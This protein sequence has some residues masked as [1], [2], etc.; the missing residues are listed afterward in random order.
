MRISDWS[1][2]VCSSDLA[3]ILDAELIGLQ[4]LAAREAERRDLRDAHRII[5]EQP[6]QPA[7]QP[8]IVADR[9]TEHRA[10]HAEDRIAR[11]CRLALLAVLR[12]DMAD[13]VP[14]HAGQL[15]LVVHQRHQLA[16]D[17]DIAPR[18]REGV[19]HRSE[20]HT[21]ELQSLMRISYAVFCLK[22]KKNQIQYS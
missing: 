3:E 8:A 5:L 9:A 19:V 20:E 21:S 11:R 14:E 7:E 2:D 16:G 6:A 4:F 18:N 10:E 1:S 13:F 15:R 22:K 17:V 12:G